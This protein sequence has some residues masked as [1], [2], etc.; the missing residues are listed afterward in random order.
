MTRARNLAAAALLALVAFS[1]SHLTAQA[2]LRVLGPTDT[3]IGGTHHYPSAVIDEL[4]TSLAPCVDPFL[5]PFRC[6]AGSNVP[7]DAP[8]SIPDNIP[9]EFFYAVADSNL[10]AIQ[11]PGAGATASKDATFRFALEAAVEPT[12]QQTFFSRHRT[13]IRG[14][15]IIGRWYRITTPYT[16]I[17]AQAEDVSGRGDI[18]ITSDLGGPIAVVDDIPTCAFNL[19]LTAGMTFPFLVWDPNVA[20]LAPAGTI[21]D[22][23]IL[24]RVTG[25]P[26]NT[27]FVRVQRIS[28]P[29]GSVQATI[30][31]SNLF[32]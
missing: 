15:L 5:G 20:P 18:N 30:A 22:V 25:S 7:N 16:V 10:D 9:E 4:G 11:D 19:A 23:N 1:S 27:N 28:G 14:G 13:R 17:E 2:N 32:I 3:T 26:N 29:G 21:G 12:G 6:I 24:H 8:P 31:D